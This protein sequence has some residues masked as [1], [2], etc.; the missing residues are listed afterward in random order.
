MTITLCAQTPNWLEDTEFLFVNLNDPLI[1]R[2]DQGAVVKRSAKHKVLVTCL[3][4]MIFSY[5]M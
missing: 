1:L 2:H 5:K 4:H 3:P